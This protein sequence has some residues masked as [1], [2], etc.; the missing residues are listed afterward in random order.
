MN[1]NRRRYLQ[2]LAALSA[3]VGLAGCG[4]F[5]EEDTPSDT[6]SSPSPTSSS[7]PTA[8]ATTQPRLQRLASAWGLDEAV[9]LAAAG[10]DPSG[11]T[12]IDDVFED[13]VGDDTLVYLPSGTYR[14]AESISVNGER[15]IGLAGDDATVVPPE[16]NDDVLF[17]FGW[18][19]PVDAAFCAG[20]TFDFSADDTGGRPILARA[21]DTV[22][23]EDVTVE[24]EADVDQDLVRVDVT[25]AAGSGM[26][27]RLHLP[28]GAPAGTGVTGCEV[29]DA[30]RGDV[31]FVD[32]RIAGFPDNGLYANPPE[33][34]VSVLGGRYLNNGVAGVRVEVNDDA[35]VR[36][37][38]VRCDDAEGAGE[39]MRGIRLRAGNSVLVEDCLVEM[40]EVTSSDGA[41]T[42]ASELGG[43]TVRNCLLRVDA[44]GVNAIR[45]K[46]AADEAT[47]EGPFVCDSIDITGNASGGAAIEAADR[48]GVA[49]REI[50]IH[51]PGPDRDGVDASSISGEFVDSRISV[52]G[53]PF[54]LTDAELDRRDVTVA[55][56]VSAD[57]DA[58]CDGV[59]L[60]GIGSTDS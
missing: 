13:H 33:G 12:P 9:D 49:F 21:N 6:P 60:S 48:S 47:Q 46:Q 25:S 4:A 18:D 31:S 39:N 43:G 26:V 15:R 40:L 38:H 32:C 29:G 44:D 58:P 19:T 16:G 51:Q 50:C 36:G 37:V 22:F 54:V 27:R 7:T 56:S 24:G 11:E 5:S 17:G 3:G 1:Q 8:E 30:N 41:I 53:D 55:E 59:D 57:T 23:I 35:V 28:D 45:M 10:A 52:T 14:L 20:V 34:S 42:F 2:Q